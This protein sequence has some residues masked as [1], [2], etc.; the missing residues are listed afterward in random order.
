MKIRSITI[1]IPS[2]RTETPEMALRRRLIA[3]SKCPEL[4]RRLAQR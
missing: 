2:P 3:R 4:L 1:R